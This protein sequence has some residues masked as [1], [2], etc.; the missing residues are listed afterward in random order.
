MMDAEIEAV[1]AALRSAQLTADV[2]ALDALIDDDLLFTGPNGELATKAD[3]LAAHR[4]GL[5]RFTAHEPQELRMRHVGNDVVVV[6]L[7][8]RL[9]VVVAGQPISGTYRYTRVWARTNGRW[10]I[11][12]GHVSE[13]PT[14]DG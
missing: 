8:A 13:V 12:A 3:D 10:R 11:V 2:A 6:A 5:V 9:T 4:S 14:A 7:R 1:E